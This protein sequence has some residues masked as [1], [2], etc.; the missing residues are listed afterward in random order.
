M[1]RLPRLLLNTLT[2]L[3]LLLC[4]A[5]TTLWLRSHFASD[6]LVWTTSAGNRAV[7]SLPGELAVCTLRL[8]DL[9]D[10]HRFTYRRDTPDHARD[11]VQRL[12]T[13]LRGAPQLFR[14]QS[15]EWH[16]A[17]FAYNSLTRSGLA[18]RLLRLPYWPLV[19]ATA[20]PP[21]WRLLTHRHH[22]RRT[23]AAQGLCP[24]CGYDLRATPDRC[25]EC[26]HSQRAD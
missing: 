16:R 13:Y 3:S 21:A 24:R 17:G 12:L 25:P 1:R 15:T 20:L 22:R 18:I 2:A 11:E 9:P 23:R 5:T 4:L 10:P 14:A 6:Q 8:G 19:A 7:Y 26:G